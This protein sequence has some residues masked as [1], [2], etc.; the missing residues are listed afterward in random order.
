MTS[1]PIASKIIPK[2]T[3]VHIDPAQIE[4]T[5]DRQRNAVDALINEF[6]IHPQLLQ[7]VKANFMEGMTKGLKKDGETMA[8]VTSYVMGRLDG[9]GMSN[10]IFSLIER[11]GKEV[12]AERGREITKSLVCALVNFVKASL[13]FLFL[14]RCL[15]SVVCV[16]VVWS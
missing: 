5:S 4:Y 6:T 3:R 14:C 15:P 11:V 8:M 12:E 7:D 9:S 1:T 16:C 13:S 10:R 2:A